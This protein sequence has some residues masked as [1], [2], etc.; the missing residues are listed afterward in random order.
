MASQRPVVVGGTG[1]RGV[2][3]AAS[4]EARVFGIRS[5]MSTARAL[6]LCPYTVFL[7]ADHAHYGEVSGRVMDIFRR[8]TPLVEPLSLD[9]AFL[10]VG[11][12]GRIHGAPEYVAS[13][14]RSTVE[15]EEQL[16]CS[17]GVAPNKFLAKLASEQAQPRTGGPGAEPGPRGFVV[18]AARARA[19]E[20]LDPLGPQ[21]C[22]LVYEGVEDEFVELGPDGLRVLDAIERAGQA[23]A[24]KLNIGVLLGLTDWRV[25]CFWLALHRSEERR[26]GKECRSRWSPYP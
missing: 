7:P 20:Q 4:Y 24:R 22:V 18:A 21:D 13:E 26:V 25:D 17:V 10:D 15:K 8:F 5:A 9:E 12:V 6:Q 2:V 3:A 1:E 14:I 16:I 11:G 19:E 23:G